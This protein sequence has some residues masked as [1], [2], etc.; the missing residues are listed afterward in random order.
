M[1]GAVSENVPMTEAD[2]HE[3]LQQCQAGRVSAAEAWKSVETALSPTSVTAQ[4]QVD[5]NRA[6]RCGYPEV[7]YGSGKTPEAI[8]DVFTAQQRA[9]QNS[10]VTRVTREQA[11][12]VLQAFPQARYNALALAAHTVLGSAKLL[13]ET[14]EHPGQLKDMVTSPG[15]TAIAGLHTLEAGGLRTTLMNAVEAATRRSR[16]LGEASLQAMAMGRPAAGSG[17]GK[18]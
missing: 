14:G 18:P 6:A 7:V 4:A 10:L 17:P 15:G 11:A 13:L 5:L 8:V 12:A 9:G 16:E 2:F 3:L 1:V